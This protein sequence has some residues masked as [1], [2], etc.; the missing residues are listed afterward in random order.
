MR[1]VIE[2]TATGKQP[3]DI[4]FGVGI[5]GAGGRHVPIGRG[6]GGSRG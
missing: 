1:F 3:I 5:G 6:D 4:D 2:L